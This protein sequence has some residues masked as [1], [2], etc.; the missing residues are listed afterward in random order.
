MTSR[1][2]E[3]EI[4]SRSTKDNFVVAAALYRS[5]SVLS[6]NLHFAP[7]VNKQNDYDEQFNAPL[8]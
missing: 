3:N 6:I 7:K 8:E 4:K 1:I 5:R 2:Y